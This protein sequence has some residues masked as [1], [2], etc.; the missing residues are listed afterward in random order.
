M[1][2]NME[3]VLERDARLGD[4]EDKSGLADYQYPY[5]F[6]SQPDRNLERWSFPIRNIC[7][8]VEAQDVVEEHKGR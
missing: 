6:R 3:K 5:S 1:R 8:Q 2:N 7:S 4:L